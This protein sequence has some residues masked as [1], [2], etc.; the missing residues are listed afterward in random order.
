LKVFGSVG[1]D[2]PK[3]IL[4]APSRTIS[5][6]E[7]SH[8]N[9]AKR[10][11]RR[12]AY[13]R[14][15]AVPLYLEWAPL[16]S[17]QQ[18]PTQQQEAAETATKDS[19]VAEE[20]ME[21]DS[22]PAGPTPTIFV[23]NLNFETTNERLLEFFQKRVKNV[24]AVRIPQKVAPVQRG[25]SDNPH[26]FS[27]GYGFVEFGA[28]DAAQ[29]ALETLQGAVLD[30]HKL[31]LKP[32]SSKKESTNIPAVAGDEK[33]TTKL[34]V[35]NVPFQATRKEILQL[36]GSFGPLKKVRCP[37]KFDG[38]HRGFAFVEYRTAKEAAAAMKSLSRTHLYGRHLVLEWADKRKR[39]NEFATVT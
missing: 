6:V 19:N 11:F 10:A 20:P 13:K 26:M 18:A 33:S 2:A 9:D 16:A 22:V 38:N 28:Q 30:G 21:E 14:F 23:K 7:Y 5:V 1:G 34:M 29:K 36:F 15:K 31:E 39:C 8:G 25:N 4:L 37:K 32:S 3:N 12:L 17:I 27:M 35:R 24:R